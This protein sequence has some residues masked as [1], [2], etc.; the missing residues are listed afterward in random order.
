MIPFTGLEDCLLRMNLV[1]LLV[2]SDEEEND[3]Q[4]SDN[5]TRIPR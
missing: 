2:E 1:N 4:E 5:Q 3:F